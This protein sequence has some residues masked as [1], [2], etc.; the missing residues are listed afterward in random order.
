M[1]ER[2]A[3]EAGRVADLGTEPG[4]T[5]GGVEPEEIRPAQACGASAAGASAGAAAVPFFW[6]RGGGLPL[7][8]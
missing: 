1:L 5:G 4:R 8:T 3:M 6:K 7:S 2:G